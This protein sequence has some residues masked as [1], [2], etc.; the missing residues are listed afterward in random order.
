MS[1]KIS[2]FDADFNPIKKFLQ[3]KVLAQKFRIIY[4]LTF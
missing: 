4:Y 3:K 1:I 2:E